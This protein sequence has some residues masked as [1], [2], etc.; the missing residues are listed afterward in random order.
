[1]LGTWVDLNSTMDHSDNASTECVLKFKTMVCV[2]FPLFFPQ[3]QCL[4]TDQL[5]EGGRSG[6]FLLAFNH[7]HKE[8]VRS[9]SQAKLNVSITK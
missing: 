4:I 3:G 6:T 9:P 7:E 1:M 5:G 2:K 8:Y